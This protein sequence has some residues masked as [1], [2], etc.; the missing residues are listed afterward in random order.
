MLITA[1]ISLVRTPEVE[2]R[3]DNFPEVTKLVHLRAGRLW[4]KCLLL[5][6][7]PLCLSE[8]PA[9]WG[10]RHER[11]R[12]CRSVF[13]RPRILGSAGELGGRGRGRRSP[14]LTEGG[15]RAGWERKGWNTAAKPSC[16]LYLLEARSRSQLS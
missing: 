2:S 9:P 12:E 11:I 3:P 6:P 14:A 13:P 4:P 1:L 5:T 7:G 10:K 15:S 16:S 8:P